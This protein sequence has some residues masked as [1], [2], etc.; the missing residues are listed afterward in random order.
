[1]KSFGLIE[2]A[3]SFGVVLALAVWDLWRTPRPNDDDAGPSESATERSGD[4]RHT[5]RQ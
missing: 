5:E 1:M 3:F 4:S 2:M